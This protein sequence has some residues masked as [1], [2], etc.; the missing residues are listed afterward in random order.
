MNLKLTNKIIGIAGSASSGKDSFFACIKAQ[1]G[2]SFEFRR[3]ALADKLKYDLNE[4]LLSKFGI[5]AF[6]TNKKEKDKVRPLLVE[7]AKIR[8]KESNGT[9][10]TKQV[11]L[12]I[13]DYQYKGVIPVITD[14]RYMEFDADEFYWLKAKNGFLIYIAREGVEPANQDEAENNPKLKKAADLVVEWPSL[15]NEYDRLQ[16][17]RSNKVFKQIEKYL[18]G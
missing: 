11:D 9:F 4:F 18:N 13:Q 1:F 10:Y 6:T 17:L 3:V 16:W 8:R 5:S 7:Y 15:S 12:D 2:D 14:I